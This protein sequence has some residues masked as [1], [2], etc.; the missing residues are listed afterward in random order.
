MLAIFMSQ[1]RDALNRGIGTTAE[2]TR[3]VRGAAMAGTS[4]L[5]DMILAAPHT[6]D[7]V[8]GQNVRRDGGRLIA[9]GGVP[10]M[11]LRFARGVPSGRWISL[12]YSSSYLDVLVRPMLRFVTPDGHQERMLP[13]GLFGRAE[14]IGRVP[15]GT[16]DVLL[17]PTDR[18]GPFGFEIERCASVSPIAVLARAWPHDRRRTLL[19]IGS[20]VIGQRDEARRLL[21]AAL[22][23][24]RF[25]DYDAWRQARY[26]PFDPD[27]FDAARIGDADLPHVRI[28]V[29]APDG[30]RD[31]IRRLLESFARQS[32]PHWSLG[33][34]CPDP[35]PPDAALD[36][37]V[38]SGRLLMLGSEPVAGALLQGT[39]RAILVG[40]MTIDDAMP[41]YALPVLAAHA[42]ASPAA[43]FFYGDE[44]AT[45]AQGRHVDPRLKP[46][47]SPAFD[48][49]QHYTA[50]T[51]F[52]RGTRLMTMRAVDIARGNAL[53]AQLA[54]ADANDVVHI[55]RVML[56][57]AAG[58]RPAAPRQQAPTAPASITPADDRPCASI[59]IPSKD[60]ARLLS[61]CIE[62]LRM[63]AAP[64]DIEIVIADNGSVEDGTRALYDSLKADRRIR[65][66]DCPGP[67]NFS[68]QCNAAA[69]AARGRILVFL[70]N[71]IAA[72]D[73]NWLQPLL[74]WAGRDDVGAVGARLLYP[75]GHLQ[76]VGV[77]VGLNGLAG[78]IDRN[79]P[80]DSGGYL[81][82][83]MAVHEVSAVTGACL[84]VD[85]VKFDAV[86]GFDAENL[87]IEL[88]DIDL[89]LRLARRGW[90]TILATESV[91]VHHE[92]ASRGDSTAQGE[93]YRGERDVFIRRWSDR[94][95]DDPYFHPALSLT[96]L[97][98]ALG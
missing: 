3:C 6:V 22:G 19:A 26:R 15:E 75:S 10:W 13:A 28:V 32:H 84:A 57:R 43:S 40:S 56:T 46:D 81:K 44:D 33:W 25:E 12:T 21:H 63:T 47:W 16:T 35:Q 23:A 59:L 7:L 8:P 88:S 50:G 64:G 30:R 60:Q 1:V 78:H 29:W 66:I 38:D 24:T 97:R 18:P 96:S 87:P 86:G 93:R 69:Q 70:N 31:G 14:W 71:D 91:L 76:H 48:A 34:V 62:S 49:A 37:A 41:P 80:R 2:H 65:V 79:E 36:A 4:A 98:T 74:S 82:R 85:K 20:R 52:V 68:R 67:F 58:A 55:R 17:S 73:R 39:S 45:D 51:L 83:R 72:L 77:V 53:A 89:C 42:A 5:T 9:D 61:T 94:L 92:S 90:R 11:S 27:G 95:R 54:G